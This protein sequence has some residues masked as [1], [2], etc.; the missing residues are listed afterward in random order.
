MA[1]PLTGTYRNGGTIYRQLTGVAGVDRELTG[2]EGLNP[3]EN[4][5]IPIQI[6]KKLNGSWRDC[7]PPIDR[8]LQDGRD[9]NFGIY[10]TGGTK[11]F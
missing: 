4:P 9:Q 3:E 10:G 2:L 8:N 1:G 5:S 7:F 11:F 6:P